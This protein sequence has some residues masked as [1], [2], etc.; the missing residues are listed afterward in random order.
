MSNENDILNAVIITAPNLG[1]CSAQVYDIQTG[2]A[3]HSYKGLQAASSTLSVT[4]S[5]HVVM[6]ACKERPLL[7]A[8]RLARHKTLEAR[9]SLPGRATA[10]AVSPTLP[11]TLVAAIGEVLHI[12]NLETGAR[13]ALIQRHFQPITC[14]AFFP[15]GR[16]FASAAEDGFVYVWSVASVLKNAAGG[17]GRQNIQPFKQLGQHSDKVT[18]LHI[19]GGTHGRLVS[20]SSDQTARVYDLYSLCLL[21]T[22][23]WTCEVTGVTLNALGTRLAVGS[24]SGLVVLID[25]NPVNATSTIRVAEESCNRCHEGAVTS[26]AFLLSGHT[27][28]SAGMDGEVKVWAMEGRSAGIASLEAGA[29]EGARHRLALQRTI[30]R[31][32]GAIT[33]MLTLQLNRRSLNPDYDDRDRSEP[34]SPLLLTPSLDATTTVSAPVDVAVRYSSNNDKYIQKFSSLRGGNGQG[35]KFEVLV[36]R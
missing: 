24:D 15:C 4:G 28:L 23:V 25:I 36:Q 3:L 19:S 30:H 5:E 35:Q 20:G 13:L 27:V 22:V 21:H 10:L 29:V 8:W 16:Y 32:K 17:G 9:L 33:N 6:C 34:F 2:T 26:L 11:T 12:Y 1:A 7:Q 14:V 18:C 31:G